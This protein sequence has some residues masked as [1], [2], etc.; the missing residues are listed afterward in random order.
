[1]S[2]YGSRYGKSRQLIFRCC[3]HFLLAAGSASIEERKQKAEK[4][5]TS[6]RPLIQS[7]EVITFDEAINL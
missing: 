1:M 2:T 3:A 5:S 6:F 4:T 7:R